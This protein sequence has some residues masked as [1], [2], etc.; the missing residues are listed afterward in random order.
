M[1]TCECGGIMHT[2]PYFKAYV[3]NKCRKMIR[4]MDKP[5]ISQVQIK[6]ET[7]HDSY[8]GSDDY[9]FSESHEDFVNRV[10][11]EINNLNFISIISVNYVNLSKKS[12][13]CNRDCE[14]AIITYIESED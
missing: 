7:R 6:R 2:D 3:C 1:K 14:Y 5:K 10:T 13:S 8:G 11:Q 4:I 12:G 9:D